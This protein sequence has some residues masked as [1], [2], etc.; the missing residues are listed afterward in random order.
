MTDY[1]FRLRF[2]LAD[3]YRINSDAEE[4]VLFLTPTN[5]RIRLRTSAL[6]TPIN[7]NPCAAVIGGP[8]VS[9]NEA[10]DAA[11]QA[12][13]ALLYWSVEQRVGIDFGDGRQ[14][15]GFTN[16]GLALLQQQMGV[17]VRNDV[18]GIDVYEAIPGQRFVGLG[19]NLRVGKNPLDLTNT[20]GREFSEPRPLTEKQH[21]AAEIYSGSFF[22]VSQRSRFI[23]LVTAVEALL[24][25]LPRSKHAQSLVDKMQR[26]ARSSSVDDAT[27]DAIIS[28][29]Q[30]F[31]F[32]S[33]GQAGRSLARRLLPQQYYG[34]CTSWVFFTTCYELRSQI[35]HR[36]GVE[37]S[38]VDLL[39]L[40]N[41]TEKFVA[42]LVL[43]SFQQDAEQFGSD[44][45][46]VPEGK[47]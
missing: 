17:P 5:Q 4:I 13:A 33:I 42:D 30:R 43:T 20:F 38:D 40:T 45:S 25:P 47:D 18:H 3:S 6:D 36:G 23:T 21:L 31:R 8:Y 12:K 9:A 1:N 41:E 14:R 32:E 2:N 7:A 46:N 39:E 34:E 35:L 15:S 10:R 19:G 28:S 26:L 16:A 44:L 22:D 29:L 27:R 24:E 37:N 11:L